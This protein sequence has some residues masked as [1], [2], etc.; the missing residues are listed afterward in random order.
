MAA[1]MHCVA[2]IAAHGLYP[3]AT[4]RTPPAAMAVSGRPGHRGESAERVV[5]L[6]VFVSCASALLVTHL[7]WAAVGG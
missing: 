5:L 6:C 3:S 1:K 7:R 2:T 4:S